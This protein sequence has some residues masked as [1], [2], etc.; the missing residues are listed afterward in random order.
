ML[1]LGDRVHRL[2]PLSGDFDGGAFPTLLPISRRGLK[3][4][5]SR[6]ERAL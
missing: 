5:K 6:I 2:E 3:E 4:A 1:G